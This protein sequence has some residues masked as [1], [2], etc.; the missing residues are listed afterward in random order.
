MDLAS[1]K[2]K[3]RELEP[4]IRV[5][6][7][8]LSEETVAE[9]RKQLKAKRLIKIKLLRNF[10]SGK[11]KDEVIKSVVDQTGAVMVEKRGFIITL[12]QRDQ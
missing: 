1:Q 7:H 2:A 11:D 12:W 8:G 4:T 9:I 3:A 5:G 6:K 10:I